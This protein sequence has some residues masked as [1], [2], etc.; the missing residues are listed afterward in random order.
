LS[1]FLTDVETE[2]VSIRIFASS[3]LIWGLKER[4]E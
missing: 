2:A 4:F 3:A 1:Q